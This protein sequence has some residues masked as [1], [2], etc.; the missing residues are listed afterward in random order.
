MELRDELQ[1]KSLK[2]AVTLKDLHFIAKVN[3]LSKT[4]ST[5]AAASKLGVVPRTI[6]TFITDNNITKDEL[7]L[8]RQSY[9]KQ[10]L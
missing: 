1:H 9:N 10:V 7:Y 5:K 3:A 8:M 4:K 6:A 2:Q